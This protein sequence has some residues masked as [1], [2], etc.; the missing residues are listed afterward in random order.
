MIIKNGRS[1]IIFGLDKKKRGYIIIQPIRKFKKLDKTELKGIISRGKLNWRKILCWFNIE[2]VA[3]DKAVEKNIQG[4]I[5]ARAKRGNFFIPVLKTE[6]KT[7][8]IANIINMGFIIAQEIPKIE[9]AYFVL[10]CLNAISQ[11]V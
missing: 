11:R 4:K 8:D 10:S 9:P 2:N 7:K 1:K 5:P 3:S 6:T